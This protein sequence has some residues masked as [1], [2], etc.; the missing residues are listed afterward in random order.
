MLDP[1]GWLPEAE[2]LRVGGRDR[3]DHDC[4]PGRTMIVSNEVKG[5]R[6]WCFRCGEG[7]FKAKQP[8][9]SDMVELRRREAEDTALRYDPSLPTPMVQDPREWPAAA[10]LWLYRAGLHDRRIME[11]GFYFHPT[12]QRVV[13]PVVED[14]RVTYWQARAVMPGQAPKYIN[15]RVDREAVLPRYGEGRMVVLTEDILSAVRVGEVAE[16]WSLMGTAMKAPVLARL[17]MEDRPVAVCSTRTVPGERVRP[18][19]CARCGPSGCGASTWCPPRT[20]SYS[21]SRRFW[22]AYSNSDRI[23]LDNLGRGPG[24]GLGSGSRA[25]EPSVDCGAGSRARSRGLGIHWWRV[26]WRRA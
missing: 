6:A 16:A 7:G 9:L 19:C 2:A 15:P 4:G 5:Y 8:T 24:P 23:H 11:L 17:S 18:R 10:R 25:G 26:P 3:V 12:T 21:A 20:P 1:S 14:G 13:L 22:N